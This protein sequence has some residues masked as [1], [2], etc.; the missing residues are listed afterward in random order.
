M[1]NSAVFFD[2]D[3]TLNIDPGYLGDPEQ[4]RLFPGVSEAISKLKEKNFKIIV[5]S[6]QSGIARGLFTANEVEAVNLRINELLKTDNA[7][8]DAFYYCPYHPDF[9][10]EE[11]C[12]CRKPSPMLVLKAASDLNIDLSSSYFVGDMLSDIECGKNAGLK[13]ILL[14]NTLNEEQIS[15]MLVEDRSPDFIAE[16]LIEASKFIIN[17]YSGGN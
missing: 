13:T 10:T 12:K 8:V 17:D 3:G 16:N 6:N 14:K 9:N 5:I 1:G 15:S 7:S 11:E 2:R 4:V